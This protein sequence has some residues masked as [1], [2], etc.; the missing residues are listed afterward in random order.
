MQEGNEKKKKGI[1]VCGDFYR[2]KERKHE[3]EKKLKE[4]K[5]REEQQ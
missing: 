1:W 5:E 2:E 4:K 3:L